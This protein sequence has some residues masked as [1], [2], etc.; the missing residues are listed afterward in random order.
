V[1][2]GAKAGRLMRRHEL[3]C[4]AE[5][6]TAVIEGRK[7]FEFRRNDRDFRVGDDLVLQEYLPSEKRLTGRESLRSVGYILHGPAYGIPE[8]F[9]VASWR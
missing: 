7:T 8:G 5:Q 3:K 6:F 4:D 1:E 9:C 2:P